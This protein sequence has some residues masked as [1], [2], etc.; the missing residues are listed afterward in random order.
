MKKPATAALVLHAQEQLDALTSP[1]RMEVVES[2]ETFGPMTVARLA[3]RMERPADSL[4][5]HMRKLE[6][7]GIV[8]ETERKRSG[9]RH[10]AVYR[11][12]SARIAVALDPASKR[13]VDSVVKLVSALLRRAD[14]E[15]RGAAQRGDI[16]YAAACRA[17]LGRRT[18]AYL[19]QDA[20]AEV[21]RRLE[22]LE[23]FVRK[24][25][26][27]KRGRPFSWMTLM[28]PLAPPRGT[29]RPSRRTNGER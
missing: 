4:Y 23:K 15:F 6:R 22:S 8:V 3:E 9:R 24:Q 1:V 13:S 10:E 7:V 17:A 28:V 25:S 14:R 19:T 29:P 11:L 12:V 20:L 2:L 21:E 26:A 18:R 16:Q 27:K 5:Y